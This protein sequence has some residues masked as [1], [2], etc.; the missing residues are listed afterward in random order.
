[1]ASPTFR[2]HGASWLVSCYDIPEQPHTQATIPLGLNCRIP[3]GVPSLKQYQNGEL[4]SDKKREARTKSL[5]QLSRYP[6]P[7]MTTGI[8]CI[9]GS[10][11]VIIRPSRNRAVT[12]SNLESST[13]SFTKVKFA[14][15]SFPSGIQV[16][17]AICTKQSNPPT[18]E[19]FRRI[20][21]KR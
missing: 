20:S 2:Q 3:R 4:R 11:S 16:Y 7:L 12:F 1:M 13:R 6:T 21:E 10:A 18:P 9:R 5:R 14:F 8:A 17:F 15:K 19:R